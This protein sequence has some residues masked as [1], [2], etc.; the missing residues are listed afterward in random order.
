[1]STA[2]AEAVSKEN[3]MLKESLE[4]R[5]LEISHLNKVNSEHVLHRWFSSERTISQ[6]IVELEHRLGPLIEESMRLNYQKVQARLAETKEVLLL[7]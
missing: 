4:M 6:K 7:L 2:T 3:A 5:L 1:M